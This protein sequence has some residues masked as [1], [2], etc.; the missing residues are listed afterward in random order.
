MSSGLPKMLAKGGAKKGKPKPKTKTKSAVKKKLKAVAALGKLPSGLPNIGEPAA[1]SEVAAPAAA[2]PTP[3]PPAEP[4]VGSVTV[5]YNHYKN[6]FPTVDGVLLFSAVDEEFCISFV[7]KGNFKISLRPNEAPAPVAA[8]AADEATAAIGAADSVPADETAA[9]DSGAEA[10][11]A[12]A[13]A[14]P[15]RETT[16]NAGTEA[17]PAAPAATDAAEPRPPVPTTVHPSPSP[18]VAIED[19]AEPP[20]DSNSDRPPEEFRGVVE[21]AT[22]WLDVE[23]DPVLGVGVDGLTRKTKGIDWAS[24]DGGNGLTSAASNRATDDITNE[25]KKM[26]AD[27]LRDGGE[28]YKQ[29][30]EARELESCLFAG[31]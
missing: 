22:Y 7:F 25:L 14:A 30:L 31:I 18:P 26:S 3:P 2:P 4:V 6:A 12:D 1:A 17:T 9:T 16:A 20:P 15:T 27:E 19:G 5:R 21:G 24:P 11:P 29:L 8:V 13:D 28:R 23:E 10:T